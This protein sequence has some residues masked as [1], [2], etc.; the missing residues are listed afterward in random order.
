MTRNFHGV[1]LL[2]GDDLHDAGREDGCNP[3]KALHLGR[4]LYGIRHVLVDSDLM[5]MRCFSELTVL[6]ACMAHKNSTALAA[7]RPPATLWTLGPGTG[8]CTYFGGLGTW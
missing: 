1:R 4:L 5:H 7:A 3:P 8:T 6:H 2:D